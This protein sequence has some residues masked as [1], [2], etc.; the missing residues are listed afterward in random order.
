MDL[1]HDAVV[2]LE[3]TKAAESNL[4]E[5]PYRGSVLDPAAADQLVEA[6]E[7]EGLVARGER[8]FRRDPLAPARRLDEVPELH[9]LVTRSL[10]RPD[11]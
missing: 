4:G 10:V 9:V 5:H 1:D 7:T 8:G 3:E 6:G 2:E 11:L